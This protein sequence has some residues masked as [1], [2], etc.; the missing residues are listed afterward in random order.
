MESVLRG[1]A[2]GGDAEFLKGI[3]KRQWEVDVLLRVVVLRPVE[4]V[5]DA[6]R[7]SSG[8]GDV[9]AGRH[10]ASADGSCLD[11]RTDAEHELRG[12]ASVER[13][14]EDALALDDVADSG[15][16]DVD[17]GGGCFDCHRF[18]ERPELE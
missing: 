8:N 1:Q 14:L 3:G 13:Q 17:D 5:A 11:R 16:A 2:A 15:A 18:L 9:D 7:E 6:G 4:A 10:P 12:V